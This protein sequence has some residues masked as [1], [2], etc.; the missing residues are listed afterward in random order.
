MQNNMHILSAFLVSVLLATQAPEPKAKTVWDGVYTP[1]QAARGKAIF[2]TQC[3]SCHGDDLAGATAQALKGPEFTE[4]WREDSLDSLFNRIRTSMPARSPGSLTE[5]MYLDVVSHILAANMYPEGQGELTADAVRN[6]AI[7]G[8]EGP[9]IVPEFALVQMV[10]C[11]AQNPDKS[12]V[13]TN[14][15]VPL[16][17]RSPGEPT[18]AELK[19]AASRALGSDTYRLLYVDSF[20]TGF[21]P[22]PHKGQKMEAKGFLIR[23]PELRLS[24]TWLE[25]LASNCGPGL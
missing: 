3:G 19:T 8:K 9:A 25:M 15:S 21:S 4:R 16:R 11:L 7:V 22:D 17:T 14:A 12:W 5:Q 10:G 18:P 24:V 1:A 6:V 23:K 20:K 13:L 2:E